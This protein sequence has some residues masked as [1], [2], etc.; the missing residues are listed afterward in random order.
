MIVI[1]KDNN[2]SSVVVSSHDIF[3]IGYAIIKSEGSSPLIDDASPV[4]IKYDMHSIVKLF[5][6]R[7][8]VT[9]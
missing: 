9:V 6:K 3:V 5:S 2:G 8:P 7:K 1:V 4:P